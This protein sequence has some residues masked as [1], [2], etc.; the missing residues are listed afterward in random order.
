MMYFGPREGLAAW[1]SSLGYEWQPARHGNVADWAM[2]LVNVGF[3]KGAGQVGGP[4]RCMWAA[5]VMLAVMLAAAL[6]T[7]KGT[8]GWLS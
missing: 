7:V 3:D 6:A 1:L 2:D 8:K 5:A 4:G